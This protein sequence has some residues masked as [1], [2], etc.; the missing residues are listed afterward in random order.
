MHAG[1]IIAID[2]TTDRKI[3]ELLVDKSLNTI[4][5]SPD[6]DT[7]YV[8]SRGPNNAEDYTRKGPAF[9]KVYAVDT[10]TLAIRDWTWG[11]NQPTGLDVSPDGTRIVFSN[12]LDDT[13]EMYEVDGR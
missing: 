8:S 7:L 11:G 3:G 9:G 10:A 1:R 13:V 2:A 6:G 4:V 12:F 5:L